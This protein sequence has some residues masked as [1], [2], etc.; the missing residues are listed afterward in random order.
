[1]NR[2]L[3]L[4]IPNAR[5]AVRLFCIPYAG[6]RAGLFRKWSRGLGECVEVCPVELPGHGRRFAERPLD[7]VSS[8]VDQLATDLQTL[9]DRPFAMFGHSLG[10]LIAFELARE[11]RRRFRVEPVRLLVAAVSA[12]RITGC[13]PRARVL[14]DGELLD[15]VQRLAGTPQTILDDRELMQMALRVIRADFAAFNAYQYRDEPPLSCPISAF[16]GDRDPE[17]RPQASLAWAYETRNVF[18]LRRFRGGHF[19]VQDSEQDVLQ[20]L[21]EELA[22]ISWRRAFDRVSLPASKL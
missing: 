18:S 13:H 8:L 6:G 2:A 4:H 12:P 1:M 15:R 16:V 3:A 22:E 19:F 9:I 5:A 11:F 10:G 7:S 21:S 17:V 20:V 14:S